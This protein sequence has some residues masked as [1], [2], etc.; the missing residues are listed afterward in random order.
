MAQ[1]RAHAQ[2]RRKDRRIPVAARV[3]LAPE[4]GARS[5]EA[6]LVDVSAGGL[7]ATCGDSTTLG[8]GESVQVEIS[9]RDGQDPRHPPLVNLRG[10]GRVVRVEPRSAGYEAAVV[11]TGALSLRE[12]FSHMLL[13]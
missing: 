1:R 2:E 10:R 13:F 7:R 11:F 3:R 5:L 8:P 6:D 4:S 9:V 12:P